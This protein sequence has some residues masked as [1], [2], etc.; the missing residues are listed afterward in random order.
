MTEGGGGEPD[1]YQ[2]V[3]DPVHSFLHFL[4]YNLSQETYLS[5]WAEMAPRQCCFCAVL[6]LLLSSKEL[7]KKKI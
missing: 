5:A 2:N 3:T 7:K 6:L 1:P 4:L